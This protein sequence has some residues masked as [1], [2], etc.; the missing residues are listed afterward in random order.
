MIAELGGPAGGNA[1]AAAGT[2]A[3]D[4]SSKAAAG[5]EATDG[6]L[7]IDIQK[8][9][10]MAAGLAGGGGNF[11]AAVLHAADPLWELNLSVKRTSQDQAHRLGSDVPFCI[12][13]QAA[14]EESFAGKLCRRPG[15]MSLCTGDRNRNRSET[16]D[17]TGLVYRAV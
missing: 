9:I 6:V 10:P 15:C 17:R 16:S 2:E 11:C 13:G 3:T 4:G 8:Q 5:T 1:E 7:T 12:M 14:A